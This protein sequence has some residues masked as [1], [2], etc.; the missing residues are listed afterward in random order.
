MPEILAK[1]LS[2]GYETEH[3]ARVFYPE[4]GLRQG[5]GTR[6]SLIYARAGSRRLAA[7]L[8]ADEGGPCAL[9]F[10][11]RPEREAEV[12]PALCRL[13]FALLR[14]ETGLRPP[15]GLL[16]GVRPLSLYRKH[17]QKGGEEA[18][19]RHF[20]EA[21]GVSPEKFELARQIERTQRPV[22]QGGAANSYS[23][24][25]SIPFCPSRCH[26]CS[27]VSQAVE[28][29]GHLLAPY[30]EK[31]EEELAETKNVAAACGLKLETVYLGGGTPTVLAKAQLE[32]LL[33]A[34]KRYF[35]PESAREYTVE[36]GRP[37]C[38]GP[39]KLELLKAYGVNRLSVNPQTMRDAVLARI[40]RRHTAEDV[41][42]C[43]AEARRAGFENIN[44]D[45]IAGLPGDD[46]PGFA[47][48]LAEVAALGPE[49]ITVH[50]L[51]LKRASTLV[52]QGSRA[53]ASPSAMVAAAAPRLAAA[54]YAPYY[55]YRQKSGVEN[56][57]N[58]GWARPGAE[59]LYNIFIMEEAHSILAVGAGAVTKLVNAQNAVIRRRYN[60]K[61]PLEYIQHFDEV[62]RRKKE[63]SKFYAGNMDSQASG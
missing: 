35:A 28:R 47:A 57:E 50:T 43:F 56:L 63:V 53:H 12:K 8:R 3:L 25:I 51:T 45:L 1:G 4:A 5:G 29:E 49:N 55:L 46:A 44:M 60:H 36:A 6:G 59:G 52:A 34:L 41:R 38:T 21:C 40:G 62:I 39:A 22:L 42:R 26:Y 16:T 17:L 54:G 31:L 27:F 37:D 9:R 15:W 61:L 7:G 30:L 14:D 20:V 19:R 13:L 48:S 23:L 18:A 24:Y 10:A 32:R 2:S 11:P 33:E 58:T